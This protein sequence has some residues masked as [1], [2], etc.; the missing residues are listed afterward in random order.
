VAAACDIERPG[1]PGAAAK[2]RA[3]LD[4]MIPDMTV[5]RIM[6]VIEQNMIMIVEPMFLKMFSNTH[7]FCCHQCQ[8]LSVPSEA[9]QI[10]MPSFNHF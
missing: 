1:G 5:S 9:R 6:A 2:A 7:V 10:Y 4:P 3:F 8:Q